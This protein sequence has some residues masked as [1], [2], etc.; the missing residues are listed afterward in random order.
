VNLTLEVLW[1]R[2][3]GYHEVATILQAVG[4][5]DELV[6]EEAEALS[7]RCTA[8][9][10][11]SPD[12]LVVKAAGLL[13][14]EANSSRGA[15]MSLTKHIPVAG[16]LGGGSADAAAA[17]VGLNA[18]WGLGLPHER[19]SVLAA[20]LGSDVPFF[21]SGGTAIA[22]G[23]GELVTPLPAVRPAWL[24]VVAPDVTLPRKTASLYGALT[25]GD[26]ADGNATQHAVARLTKGAALD[27]DMLVNT[28]ERVA[29][30]VFPSLASFA[31]ALRAAGA[32]RVHL[33]GSGPSLFS[34]VRD[35]AAGNAMAGRLSAGGLRAWCVPT[36]ASG[37]T[38][39]AE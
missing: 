26:Y 34:L 6:L 31:E 24:V 10:L 36:V 7:F 16:G 20:K 39:I 29:Y 28:F 2:P 23:R 9:E 22:T 11:D 13:A 32:E 12:N 19:L 14:S 4:L 21:L 17:L 33:A 37:V 25:R 5:W 27:A 8:P 38:L 15:D 1:R 3:D 30:R 35:E 18:L